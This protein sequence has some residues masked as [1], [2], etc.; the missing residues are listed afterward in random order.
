MLIKSEIEEMEILYIEITNVRMNEC[1]YM[2][3]LWFNTYPLIE[4]QTIRPVVEI[5]ETSLMFQSHYSCTQYISI[6]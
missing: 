1:H 5:N 4:L 2:S 6:F 3:H